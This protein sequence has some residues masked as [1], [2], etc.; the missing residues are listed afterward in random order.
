MQEIASS[1]RNRVDGGFQKAFMCERGLFE[2]RALPFGLSGDVDI[3]DQ[4][5]N[6]PS[7]EELLNELKNRSGLTSLNLVLPN[8]TNYDLEEYVVDAIATWTGNK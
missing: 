3:D 4:Q 5:E 6:V 1:L 7:V 2:F 8:T